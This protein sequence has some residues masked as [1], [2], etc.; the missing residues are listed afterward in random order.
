L[1][2]LLAWLLPAPVGHEVLAGRGELLL[3]GAIDE[4][5]PDLCFASDGSL[6]DDMTIVG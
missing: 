6:E 2:T 1:W 3:L 4:H 5:G